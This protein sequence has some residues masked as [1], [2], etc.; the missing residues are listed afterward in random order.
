[1]VMVILPVKRKKSG[2]RIPRKRMRKLKSHGNE[3]RRRRLP[4]LDG[5]LRAPKLMESPRELKGA[6]RKSDKAAL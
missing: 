2:M 1:M 5:N 6:S 4:N 3:P